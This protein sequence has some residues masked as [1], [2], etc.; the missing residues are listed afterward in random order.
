MGVFGGHNRHTHNIRR[1]QSFCYDRD[2]ILCIS[3]EVM[4]LDDGRV[5]E[6]C[7]EY[8]SGSW[9]IFMCKQMVVERQTQ[10]CGPVSIL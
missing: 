8:S 5:S 10:I 2:G 1:A 9:R 6:P 3:D 4:R 7:A